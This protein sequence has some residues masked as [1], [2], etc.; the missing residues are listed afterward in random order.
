MTSSSTRPLPGAYVEAGGS[1]SF[2]F[3]PEVSLSFFFLPKPKS[4]K[5]VGADGSM[6]C[7]AAASC[8]GSA[9]LS[10]SLCGFLISAVHR[11]LS[12]RGKFIVGEWFRA[13]FE[14]SLPLRIQKEL[15]L[16]AS[17]V[18]RFL[19]LAPQGLLSPRQSLPVQTRCWRR[20]P[21]LGQD[22][23]ASLVLASMRGSA[24]ARAQESDSPGNSPLPS[25]ASGASISVEGLKVRAGRARRGWFRCRF[26][27]FS[28]GRAAILRKRFARQAQRAAGA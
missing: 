23:L 16:D 28:G 21:F 5:P 15:P 1:G 7:E 14:A 3:L 17:S 19:K 18:S 9:A 26:C 25:Q 11:G 2:A 10:A 4:L 24:P 8:S 20:D 6:R 13:A 12:R 22:R 27:A